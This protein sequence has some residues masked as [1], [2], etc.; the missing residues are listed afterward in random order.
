MPCALAKARLARSAL[1]VATMGAFMAAE[2]DATPRIS[3]RNSLGAILR[4]AMIF[5]GVFLGIQANNWNDARL[6]RTRSAAY[7]DRIRNDLLVDAETIASRLEYWGA[8]QSYARTAEQYVMNGQ[9]L[10]F[11]KWQTLVAFFQATHFNA[12]TASDITYREMLSTGDAALIYD[13]DLRAAL[14]SYYTITDSRIRPLY[15]YMSR[16]RE[17]VRGLTPSNVS[18]YILSECYGVFQAGASGFRECSSPISDQEA[19]TILDAYTSSPELLPTL[20]LW[21]TNLQIIQLGAARQ[22]E[23]ALGLAARFAH[24]V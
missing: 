17:L 7:M 24:S 9:R 12:F 21:M 19:Q 3:W 14:A 1:P 23:E 15:A 22:R 10:G 5:L 16:Y 18:E 13:S 11:S 2:D 8:V 20:R 6:E 4:L